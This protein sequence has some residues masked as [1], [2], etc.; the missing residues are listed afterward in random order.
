MRVRQLGDSGL[1]LGILVAQLEAVTISALSPMAFAQ[2]ALDARALPGTA[3]PETRDLPR[4]ASS[5]S[6]TS[7]TSW[8]R[9]SLDCIA[10]ETS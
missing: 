2:R 6:T 8:L 4:S 5:A 9:H 7:A 3:M 1:V 10:S